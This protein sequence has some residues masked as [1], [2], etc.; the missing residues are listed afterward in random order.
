LPVTDLKQQLSN[1]VRLQTI[2]SEIYALKFEKE[3]KPQEINSLEASFEEKKL[4]LA[5]L[6]KSLLDFQ[7]QRKEN[8]L[9]LGT[10]EES[11]KKLQTQLYSLKTNKEYQ[12]MLQQIEEAKADGSVIEDKILELFEQADKVKTEIDQEKQK[13]I[14]EER[15]FL[16]QKKNIEDRIKEI[17]DRLAQ[18]DGQRKQVTPDIDTKI[19]NQYDRILS[20][21]DGLAIVTVKDNSCQGC[22]M[23]VP[24]QVINLIKM[25]ERII[26]CEVCNRM[27]YIEE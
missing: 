4:H 14:Q 22:N 11:T 2:D 17:D 27:L 13:L 7:K 16:E 19:L 23:F 20:N 12:T 26:T 6:E 8:E 21:R 10:K 9:E 5:A 3:S 18:L 25:Y 1:L 15:V 24:P